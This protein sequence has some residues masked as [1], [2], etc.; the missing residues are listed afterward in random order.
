MVIGAD[1]WAAWKNNNPIQTS[2]PSGGSGNG[3]GSAIGSVAL[4]AAPIVLGK[5]LK[6]GLSA[7]KGAAT[8]QPAADAASVVGERGGG[9]LANGAEP[10]AA[11][12][13]AEGAGI[14]A[15]PAASPMADVGSSAGANAI[16]DAG[17]NGGAALSNLANVGTTV[18]ADAATSA[19]ADA[20]ATI[21]ADA[22]AGSAAGPIGTAVG[23]GAGAL[24]AS[25]ALDDAFANGGVVRRKPKTEKEARARRDKQ[26]KAIFALATCVLIII[27][28]VIK[29]LRPEQQQNPAAVAE[30][31]KSLLASSDDAERAA[32]VDEFT[33]N[34]QPEGN[35]ETVGLLNKIA[36][37]IRT[38]RN[39]IPTAAPIEQ[40]LASKERPEVRMAFGGNVGIALGAAAD[41]MDRQKKLSMQQG[42]Y[43]AEM[44]A[45]QPRLATLAEQEEAL[46]IGYQTKV[47]Q[48]KANLGLVPLETENKRLELQNNGADQLDKGYGRLNQH[49]TDGDYEGAT[50]LANSLSLPQFG[51]AKVSSF[52]HNPTAGATATLDDGRSVLIPQSTLDRGTKTLN[53]GFKF[54]QD[55]STGDIVK[56]NEKT[57]D[58]SIASPGTGAGSRLTLPQES[59][60]QQVEI[61]RQKIAGMSPEEIRRK[62]SK[63]TDTG[64][65]NP[66][67]DPTLAQHLRLANKRKYGADPWYDNQG[68]PQQ[69]TPAQPQAGSLQSKFS[70]DPSMSGNRIG[71]RLVTYRNAAGQTVQGYEVHDASG[72][73]I[74]HYN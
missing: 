6:A 74:G 39:E 56:T 52:T 64:R 73:V 28:Q 46:R 34:L 4:G 36:Y 59:S 71:D 2:Q 51:G 10:I 38:G 35:V 60:N 53:G 69:Q 49:I 68:Q 27:Y 57:G 17:A 26:D 21:A 48:D 54:F 20:G 13:T 42:Y 55:K 63:A 45:L 33:N 62:T 3:A 37:Q 12:G 31:F 47:A 11:H 70:N 67:Y 29:Y 7:V 8:T 32:W 15:A 58:A 61:S 5:G 72:R 65:E 22:A 43:D 23:L 25:G 50:G 44:K 1:P 66:D 40:E 16:Y 19:A 30:M 24:I 18:T 9:A 41:E 14:F